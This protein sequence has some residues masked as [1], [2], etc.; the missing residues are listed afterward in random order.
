MLGAFQ[1]VAEGAKKAG[2]NNI[3][4]SQILKE[5]D[6]DGSG[7]GEVLSKLGANAELLATKVNTST[8]ALKENGSITEEFAKKNTTLGAQLEKLSKIFSSLIQSKTLADVFASG[9]RGIIAFIGAIKAIPGFIS[10]NKTA[11][12]LLTIGIATM[13]AAYIKAAVLIT[14][15]TA[16]KIYNAIV[17]RGTAIATNIAIAAQLAYYDITAL[18]TRQITLATAAQ[19]LW[20]L[21]LSLGAGP[22]GA[23]IVAVGALFFLIGNLTGAFKTLTAEQRLFNDLQKT[24]LED[25]SSQKAMLDTLTNSVNNN[26]L[27][28][29]DRKKALAELIAISPAYLSGLTL[30]NIRTQEGKK[31]IDEYVT[32]LDRMARAKATQALKEDLYK[33]SVEASV[34]AQQASFNVPKSAVGLGIE[35]SM[36]AVGLGAFTGLGEKISANEEVK[37][38]NDEI[39]A[40][41]AVTQKQI[42]EENKLY[43]AQQK[44]MQALKKD[45]IEYKNEQIK[46]NDIIARRNILMGLSPQ[47]GISTNAP[48]ASTPAVNPF[49][50]PAKDKKAKKESD[51]RNRL[52]QQL[53]D[54]QFELSQV[55]K[56]ADESEIARITKKYDELIKEAAKYHVD[57]IQLSREKDRAIAFLEAQELKKRQEELRKHAKLANEETYKAFKESAVQQGEDQKEIETKKYADGIINKRQ[58]EEAIRRIDIETFAF[59]IGIAESFV[60]ISQQASSDIVAFRKK[61]NKEEIED[62]IKSRELKEALAKREQLAAAQ[63]GVLKTPQGSQAR[64]DAQLN[65]LKV[66]HDQELLN[67]E[68]T[69]SE[70]EKLNEEYRQ[71][72]GELTIQFYLGQIEQTLNFFSQG[73]DI[74]SKL[75]SAKSAKENAAL[76]K[77]LKNNEARKNSI[78]RLEESKVITA[79]EARRRITIIEKEEDAKKEALEKKQFERTKK[80]QITQA[81]INGALGITSILAAIPGPLDLLSLGVSRYVAI[82]LNIATTAAAIKEISSKKYGKGGRLT[83]PSHTSGGMPVI[84]PVTGAKEAEVE[85]GEYILSKHTVANNRELA[86]ALLHSSMNNMGARIKPFW[87]NRPYRT[88]DYSKISERMY[89]K[90]GVYTAGASPAAAPAA[91]TPASDPTILEA[92]QQ[93]T[94]VNMAMMGTIKNLTDQLAMGIDANVQLSKIDKA[95]DRQNRMKADSEFK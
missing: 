48:A 37:K 81:I 46:L 93:T 17:T 39:A 79:Q 26:A 33:K 75:D 43:D 91:T 60:G 80:I 38:S 12:V 71:K 15:D 65:L 4:F 50:D 66:E 44:K 23:I 32:S 20:S 74:L 9:V 29:D 47:A 2:S 82:G 51:D 87:K 89:E 63:V 54:F 88:L 64:L 6:A 8:N 30:E 21:A 77:E 35:S 95:R 67:T 76:Q 3:V 41:N 27:S 69:N 28:L 5:L 55:G 16:L 53:K 57:F 84:N 94:A 52:L 62:A 58:L 92:L 70:K 40:L 11:I 85:G 42:I 24:A 45:S 68:L 36:L 7:A 18:V 22:I 49:G 90:G 1:A 86:D 13:N 72:Q 25:V 78:R 19:R 56:Q 83:G 73:L 14:R 61:K 10:E 34:K 31:I 59:Q